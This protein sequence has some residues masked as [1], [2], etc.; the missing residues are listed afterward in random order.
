MP[1]NSNS[2]PLMSL[3]AIVLDTETTGLDVRTARVVQIGAV[4]IT[5]GELQP[6]ERFE[7]LV[8]TGIAIPA[9]STAI[10]GLREG[11]LE[12]ARTFEHVAAQFEAFTNHSVIIGHNIG[13]DLAILMHEYGRLGK[14]WKRP[15]SLDTMVLSQVANPSLPNYSIEA[16]ANWLGVEIGERHTASG[17]ALTT[18]RIFL[19]LV[20]I[21]RSKGLRTL[22]EAERSSRRLGDILFQH[23]SIGWLEPSIDPRVPA[24]DVAKRVSRFDS[25]LFRHKVRDVMS[26]PPVTADPDLR[27]AE[28]VRLLVD[29]HVSAAFINPTADHEGGIITERDLMRALIA[30]RTGE[31]IGQGRHEFA[32]PLNLG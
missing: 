1:I 13:Y 22:A 25:F 16:V 27:P 8:D 17:D 11:D 30:P 4:R 14:S 21:L 15:R 32:G 29:H 3:S 6:T 20:P 23:E 9:D 2:T 19:A 24:V 18:A 7:E 12:G 10:H 26:S 5:L 31:P 28:L